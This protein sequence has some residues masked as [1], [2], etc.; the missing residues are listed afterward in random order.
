MKKFDVIVAGA[1]TAGCITAKTV[2][3]AGFEVC[4]IDRKRREDVGKKVCGDAI[5]RHYFDY[6]GLEYAAGRL[7][8]TEAST[9]Q[10]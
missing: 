1:A 7:K 4:L 9:S 5:N 10:G 8:T 3:E 6:L 2:A